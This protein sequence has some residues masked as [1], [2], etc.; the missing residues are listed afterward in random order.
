MAG[1]AWAQSLVF[2]NGTNL[3]AKSGGTTNAISSTDAF[4]N[5]P[6]FK[7]PLP[8][9]PGISGSVYTNSSGALY[10]SP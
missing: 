1:A 8:S 10:I 7:L 3:T 6:A 5:A 9:S 4:T 2:W